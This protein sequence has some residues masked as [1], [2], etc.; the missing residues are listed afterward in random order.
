[1]GPF[2]HRYP[3]DMD[4]LFAKSKPILSVCVAPL[5]LNSSTVLRVVEFVEMYRLLGATHFYFYCI[6]CSTDVASVLRHYRKHGLVDILPWNLGDSLNEVY[7]FGAVAHSNDCIYRAMAVDNYRYAAIV[8]LDEILIPLKHN[9][10]LSFMLQCDEGLTASY[11]FRNVF[12]HKKD[13]G[14]N[15]ST[16]EK[17]QNRLLYTQTKVRR[18]LEI[19]PAYTNSKFIVNTRAAVNMGTERLWLAAPGYTDH[20]L[21]PTVGLLFHYRDKCINC[22]TVM[23]V[24]YTARRFGSLIW[25]RVDDTCLQTFLKDKGI[26]PL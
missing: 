1:M 6:Q 8:S 17:A 9:S 23:L 2:F 24:D 12:F 19:M 10:L 15:F 3:R 11:V 4:Q 20:I 22:R 26:C 5:Q 13:K 18:T 14:D 16:P 25:D 21:S 7:S